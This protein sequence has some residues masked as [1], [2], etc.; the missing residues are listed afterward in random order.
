MSVSL[1]HSHRVK[2]AMN[3]GSRSGSVTHSHTRSGETSTHRLS[4]TRTRSP[5]RSTDQRE[6]PP[7]GEVVEGAL[8][9]G[10]DVVVNLV[11]VGVLAELLLEVDRLE[12]LDG[13]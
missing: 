6:A 13:D 5:P 9:A 12:H 1:T 7:G 8:H 2:P 3:R 11:Y 4:S 10:E